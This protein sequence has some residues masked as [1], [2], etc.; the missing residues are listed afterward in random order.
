MHYYD[1]ETGYSVSR[2]YAPRSA[3]LSLFDIGH[4]EASLGIDD[5]QVSAGVIAS[6]WSPGF[7]VY[8]WE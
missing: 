4:A 6:A 1:S 8:F 7:R 5:Y 3:D 2:Y